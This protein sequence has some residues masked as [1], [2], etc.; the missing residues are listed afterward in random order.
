MIESHL[1]PALSSFPVALI[2]VA[3]AAELWSWCRKRSELSVLVDL[4]L[5]VGVA[6][7]TAAFFSGYLAADFGH[8]QLGIPEERISAHHLWGKLLL[9]L[10]V[11][12]IIA[13]Q[14]SRRALYHRG[15]FLGLFRVLLVSLWILSMI[16]AFLGGDLLLSSRPPATLSDSSL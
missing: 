5:L 8:L 1:H 16:T 11:I 6:G 2:T 7:I 10:G 13:R 4:N 9:F 12:T 15:I 14:V 3:F